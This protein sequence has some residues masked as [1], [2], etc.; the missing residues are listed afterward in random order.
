MCIYSIDYFIPFYLVSLNNL[1]LFIGPH[2]LR[3]CKAFMSLIYIQHFAIEIGSNSILVKFW[4]PLRNI[5]H[6]GGF[7][8]LLMLHVSRGGGR[9]TKNLYGGL[10]WCDKLEIYPIVYRSDAQHQRI[11][12]L[13]GWAGLSDPLCG[14]Y[15]LMLGQFGLWH[16]GG[17]N[18]G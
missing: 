6:I 1:S 7:R 10:V 5:D 16:K 15:Q 12:C 11:F 9:V 18:R 4:W 8:L 2:I 17:K 14:Q 13:V 3:I